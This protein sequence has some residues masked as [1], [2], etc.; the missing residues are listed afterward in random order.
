M[1]ERWN[2]GWKWEDYFEDT[3]EQVSILMCGFD[4]VER[5]Y[6]FKGKPK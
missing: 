6:Y 1:E 2:K 3:E 4:G 5:G